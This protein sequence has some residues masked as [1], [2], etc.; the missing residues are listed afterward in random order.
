MKNKITYWVIG[1]LLTLQS[2]QASNDLDFFD[3][4]VDNPVAPIDDY[5]GWMV[6]VAVL[7]YTYMKYKYQKRKQN[8]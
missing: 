8:A 7:L 3:E 2:V 1:I 6:L 5:V 4:V